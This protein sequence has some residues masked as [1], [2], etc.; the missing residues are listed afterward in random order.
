MAL[1]LL[2][3]KYV[4]L[5]SFVILIY[6][7]AV[8]D[9]T[10]VTFS[11][12]VDRI[13]R[14]KWTGATWL[15]ALN[16]YSTELFFIVDIVSAPLPP[17]F[18]GC[19]MGPQGPLG[20]AFWLS[21]LVVDTIITILT[22]FKATQYIQANGK[23][24]RLVHVILRDGL[25]YF[26]VIL[27]ANLSN[28]LTYYLAPVRL[29]VI[30]ASFCQGITSVMV[31][32]LQL[33]LRSV[34]I[35]LSEIPISQNPSALSSSTETRTYEKQLDSGRSFTTLSSILHFFQST[36]T[37][38]ERDVTMIEEEANRMTATGAESDIEMGPINPASG[39]VPA[40]PAVSSFTPEKTNGSRK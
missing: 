12:E 18:V 14:R 31:S 21:S 9:M 39:I 35:T 17:G 16:R 4:M 20:A 15:F 7:H 22:V 40:V 3:F 36:V 19:V 6:D 29:R 25:L 11:D 27:T 13:W 1:H 38:M 30:I 37:E 24:D 5:A 2:A 10:A 34:S 28:C 33:N 23:R 8:L 32:R 26:V